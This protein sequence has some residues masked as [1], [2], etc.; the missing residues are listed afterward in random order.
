MPE[1]TITGRLKHAWNAFQ[2]RDP[3]GAYTYD[4]GPGYGRR[5]DRVR[6]NLGN[7]RSI[8]AA[9]YN[10][11][12]LDVT[13]ATIQ[14]VKLD[15]NGQFQEI[16]DSGLNR[17]FSVEANVDQTGKALVQD[18][19]LSL[20]D[21][22]V[23]AVVPVDTTGDPNIS[24][25]Y[26]IQTMRTAKILEWYPQHVR[27]FLYNEQKGRKQ[28][29]ILP[30]RS[31]A[32]IENPLYSVMNEPNSTL[33]RLVRK[34]NLLDAIDEQSGSGKLDIVVKLPYA[35]K[36]DSRRA[37]ADRRRKDLEE[38]LA[39]SKYGVAYIDAT[40]NVTQLNR[41]V[42][43]HLMEQ[44]EYLTAELFSQIGLTEAVFNGTAD[45]KV[46]TNYFSRS[47]EPITSVILDE[48][49]RKFLTKTA[50]T[51]RQSLY[52][53]RDPFKY[54]PV[55]SIADIADKFTRNEIMTSNEFRQRIG[56]KASKDPAANELRNKNL[57]SPTDV[58]STAEDQNGGQ[59]QDE[60]TQKV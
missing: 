46:L 24:G 50:R 44:I 35:V 55:T 15:E 34:L 58:K 20:F 60:Q 10:R 9:I 43:N 2:N 25:S 51:Q 49:N 56:M 17:C 29:L 23:V 45:D 14:H 1:M 38:Q 57:S 28:E 53:F 18:I 13:S 5:P 47:I 30:K 4:L 36:S 41:S 3:T 27:L 42:E 19:V 33:K 48:G 6:L 39:G 54:V 7:E 8:V 26:D 11:M 32:I 52:C 22:G 31:V 37:Q 40:E 16:I 21:E 59:K 12:A